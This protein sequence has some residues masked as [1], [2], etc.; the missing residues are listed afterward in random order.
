[1]GKD[2]YQIL[3]VPENASEADIKRAYRELA[4]KY[5]PDRN[6]G[7]AEAERRFK[8]VGEA[9][10]VLSDPKKRRQYDTIRRFGGSYDP[11]MGDQ[12]GAGGVG[13]F[14]GRGFDLGD[15]VGGGIGDIFG[16][17][18]GAGRGRKRTAPKTG[19][20]ITLTIGVD[21]LTV[22]EGGKVKI[23]VPASGVCPTCKGSGGKPGT[24][25][26]NCANCGGSG[27]VTKS[28]GGFALSQTCPRCLGRGVIPDET[29]PA[30][31]GT[32][33]A[34]G[35]TALAVKI[36]AGISEDQKIRIP[37][38]GEP[39]MNGGSPGDL[40]VR[41]RA[42]PHPRF[43]REGNDVY[44]EEEISLVTAILGGEVC[45]QT[46]HGEV[47]AKVP[48]GTQ[49][50]TKLRLKRKGIH[51]ER[52]GRIGDHYIVLK[53]TIPKRLTKRQRELLKEFAEAGG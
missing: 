39:G 28:Q 49:P 42:N 23:H 50:G 44:T 26:R 52:S 31:Y 45:T 13:G 1:M 18:F 53:I 25:Y 36:P 46:I 9:Y 7:D 40:Y 47:C 35:D 20:N 29:C 4:K 6:E 51:A 24:K 3:G 14:G 33:R 19:E 10:S 11:R 2:Y 15:L 5:H 17:F 21:F 38:R 32:G 22:A 34:Q 8:E 30:C 12:A 37:G 43:R 48:P 16:Q 41:V 27:R